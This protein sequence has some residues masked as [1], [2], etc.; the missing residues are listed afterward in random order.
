[1]RVV[2]RGEVAPV[3]GADLPAG[4]AEELDGGGLE[5]PLRDAQL[6]DAHLLLLRRLATLGD[7][8]EAAVAADAA[9]EAALVALVAGDA[10]DLLDLEEDG[11][12]IAVDADLAHV[13]QVS[14][15]L[16]LHP[17]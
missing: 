12:G 10:A 9:I 11:V 8:L 16:A 6:Q 3:A 15:R 14:R 13:L 7:D 1:V 5:A 2:D 17:E 4:A